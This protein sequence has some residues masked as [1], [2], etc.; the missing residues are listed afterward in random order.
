MFK[1]QSSVGISTVRIIP[2]RPLDI[3]L[4]GAFYKLKPALSTYY[5]GLAQSRAFSPDAPIIE[6][7]STQRSPRF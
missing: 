5:T 4:L 7:R 3:N 2:Y 1:N 6:P